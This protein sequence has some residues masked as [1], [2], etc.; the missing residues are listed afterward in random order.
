M[1]KLEKLS[2]LLI[3]CAASAKR[4][5]LSNVFCISIQTVIGPTPPG[6]GVIREATFETSSKWTS[7]THRYP[8]F[9]MGH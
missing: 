4:F 3:V 8:L 7:P 1:S 6:T 2:H 9:L 5:A